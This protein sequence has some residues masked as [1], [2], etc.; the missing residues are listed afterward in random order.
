ML[1]IKVGVLRGGPS[2]EYDVSLATGANVLSALREK[3]SDKYIAL[4]ILID[5]EGVWHVD[6]IAMKADLAVRKYDVSF[7]AL[8][9]AYGED[10]KVQHFLESH[11]VPYTGSDSL[12]SAI[13]FNKILTKKVFKDNG[14][15]TPTDKIILS[16]DV[17]TDVNKASDNLFKSFPMPFVVKPAT[18]GSSVGISLVKDRFQIAEALISAAEHSEEILIEECIQG[19]EATVG[20]IENFRNEMLYA[21][22]PVEIRSKNEFFDFEAKYEGKSEEIVPASFPENIK[23]ELAEIAKKVHKA[24]GLRHY[25]RTDFIVTPKRG[26]YTLE[27]NTLPGLTNESLIPKS[28]RAVGSDTHELIDHLIEL[29]LSK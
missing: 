7:L 15:K 20:V 18:S 23:K 11:H 24:V 16:K 29:A 8:H 3:L 14:I 2:N 25:S 21:L 6:G 4:D 26:I 12:G 10:G 27:V 28:L 17:R 19:V 5:K 13:G 1:K 22:P 9:G